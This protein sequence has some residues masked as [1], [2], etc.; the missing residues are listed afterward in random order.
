VAELTRPILLLTDFGLHDTYTGQVKAV[1]AGIL[2]GATVIDL[3]H[4]VAPFAIAEG[5]WLLETALPAAPARAVVMAVVDPGV[6][7]SRRALVVRSGERLFV[8]PDNG[9]LSCA[10]T[11]EDRERGAYASAGAVE[12]HELWDP[13]WRRPEVSPTFHGRDIFAPA[14][15]YLASGI[16][17]RH[18]GPPAPNP[19]LLPP[20]RGEPGPFGELR[21][22][23][24]HVDRFGNAITTIRGTQLFPRFALDAAGQVID[25]HVRTFSDAPGE[26]PFC[27]TDSSGF[28]AIA[29]NQGSAAAELG[30][31]RG[32]PVV[33][34]AR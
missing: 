2:P 26:R 27:H 32:D 33:V 34:R 4:E 7:T 13:L 5:A 30:L 6:G 20:F 9:L 8:G 28:I 23:I 31:R 14:A 16:D 21:G 24:V 10:F 29:L 19:A 11:D 22:Y 25:T 1:I 3:T 17:Y 12:V 15:A 18:M